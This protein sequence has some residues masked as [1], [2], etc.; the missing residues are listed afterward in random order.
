MLKLLKEKFYW[1]ESFKSSAGAGA[2]KI[3]TQFKISI[4][5][6][7]QEF[8]LYYIYDFLYHTTNNTKCYIVIIC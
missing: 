1:K 5:S 3:E 8:S 6:R 4:M 2:P 7:E